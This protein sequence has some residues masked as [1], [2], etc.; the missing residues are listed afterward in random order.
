MKLFAGVVLGIVGIILAMRKIRHFRFLQ[1]YREFYARWSMLEFSEKKRLLSH[2]FPD[3]K[4][5]DDTDIMD[6][7]FSSFMTR[8]WGE[9]KNKKF[10]DFEAFQTYLSK[11][12]TYATRTSEEFNPDAQ[13]RS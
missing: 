1:I 13:R 9:M 11:L 12:I 7:L 10:Y 3:L 5:P 2:C 6:E 4:V 8:K